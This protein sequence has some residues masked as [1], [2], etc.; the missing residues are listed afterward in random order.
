MDDHPE[1]YCSLTYKDWCDLLPTIEVKYER[2]R[3]AAQIN[4]ITYARAATLSDRN[5]SA[6]IP[7]KKKARTGV[8]HSN[9]PQKKAHKNHGIQRYCM[10]C[11][12]AGMPEKKYMPH[13][14][15]DCTDVRTN[16]TIKDGMGVSVGG[17][18]DTMNQYNKYEKKRKKELKALKKQ[19]K[20]LY[21]IAKK[22]GSRR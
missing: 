6:S 22:S 3:T 4:K 9:R 15:E 16:R 12:K 19:N 2:K 18:T 1:D 10:R 20:M 8:L 11:K 21:S 7:R 14:A 13:S 17:R 5:E